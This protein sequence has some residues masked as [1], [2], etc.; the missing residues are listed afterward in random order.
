MFDIEITSG[1]VSTHAYYERLASTLGDE[2]ARKQKRVGVNTFND[3]LFLFDFIWRRFVNFDPN[4]CH[5]DT[6]C[7]YLVAL[8]KNQ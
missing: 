4:F 2:R 5:H 7:R 3:F 8:S 6:I 1:A